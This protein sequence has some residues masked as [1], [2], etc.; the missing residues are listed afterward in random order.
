MHALP[1]PASQVTPLLLPPPQL[2]PVHPPDEPLPP[3][4]LPLLLLPL[5]LLP[6]LLLP[7]LLLP[8]APP[9]PKTLAVLSEP[10]PEDADSTN[11]AVMKSSE[12]I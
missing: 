2:K 4:L 6:L 12:T 7:L 9:S 8:D 11:P 3:P 1:V 10:H 5:L